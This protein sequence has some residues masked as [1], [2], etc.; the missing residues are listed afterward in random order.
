[1]SAEVSSEAFARQIWRLARPLRGSARALEVVAIFGAIAGAILG[2]VFA[3]VTT[4]TVTSDFNGNAFPTTTHPYV[5]VGSAIALEAVVSGWFFWAV[6]RGLQVIAVDVA[7]RHGVDLDAA[8]EDKGSSAG[9][10]PSSST[11]VYAPVAGHPA[12]WYP[13]PM[14]ESP[15]ERARYWNGSQW[16]METRAEPPSSPPT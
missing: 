12:G 2:V 11:P 4:T 14:N 15:E 7:Q 5:A 6:A 9:V 3:T 1:M 16:T 13:D 10:G 8:V